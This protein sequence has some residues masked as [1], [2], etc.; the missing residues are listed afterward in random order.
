MMTKAAR[1]GTPFLH[2][3]TNKAGDMT[4]KIDISMLDVYNQDIEIRTL[5][6]H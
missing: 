6:Q 1:T 4:N 5:K 2:G 3:K